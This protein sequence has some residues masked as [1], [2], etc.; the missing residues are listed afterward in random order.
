MD[1]RMTATGDRTGMPYRSPQWLLTVRLWY[2]YRHVHRHVHRHAYRYVCVHNVRVDVCAACSTTCVWN[3][4]QRSYRPV[5]RHWS[6]HYLD[7]CQVLLF[8]SDVCPWFLILHMRA[9]TVQL[10]C[11]QVCT[12]MRAHA[13]T[14][15]DMCKNVLARA[16]ALTRMHATDG[17]SRTRVQAVRRLRCRGLALRTFLLTL[18]LSVPF[19]HKLARI[20]R[21]HTE[22]KERAC[23]PVCLASRHT[24]MGRW[25][26]GCMRA[27]VC[28]SVWA[29]KHASMRA[30]AHG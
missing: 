30:H 8:M 13:R 25:V 17:R 7:M 29:S 18:C 5:C 20:R 16:C 24:R 19:V 12:H 9:H 3:L 15:M 21:M 6:K 4:H 2:V 22:K 1:E 10:A 11:T 26:R 28:A 23:V 27:S 14:H